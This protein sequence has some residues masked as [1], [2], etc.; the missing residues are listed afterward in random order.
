VATPPLLGGDHMPALL[1]GGDLL[2]PVC[3]AAA[4]ASACRPPSV[5]T[6]RC[7]CARW[8][9][10]PRG[11]SPCWRQPVKCWRQQAFIINFI[12]SSLCFDIN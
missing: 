7:A 5:A 6:G 4:D 12:W 11:V 2:Q 1:L 3:R 9:A 10:G 8:L